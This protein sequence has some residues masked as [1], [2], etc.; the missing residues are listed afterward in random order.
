MRTR[1][2]ESEFYGKE[3]IETRDI[4][5][6]FIYFICGHMATYKEINIRTKI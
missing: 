1:E 3:E 5:I 6:Y 4:N 2:R